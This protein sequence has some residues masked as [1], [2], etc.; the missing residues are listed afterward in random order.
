LG[1]VIATVI[2]RSLVRS[3]R[4]HQAMLARGFQGDIVSLNETSVSLRSAVLLGGLT[5]IVGL[6]TASAYLSR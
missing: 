2:Q 5:L 1:S 6:I 3:E 4:T